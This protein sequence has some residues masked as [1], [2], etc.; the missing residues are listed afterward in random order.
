MTHLERARAYCAGE[1]MDPALRAEVVQES[2]TRVF[3]DH[4]EDLFNAGEPEGTAQERANYWR[5]KAKEIYE[6]AR[7]LAIALD[8]AKRAR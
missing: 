2:R 7:V 1:H 4:M 5:E 6:D 3:D 8:E